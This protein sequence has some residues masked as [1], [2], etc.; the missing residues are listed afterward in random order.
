MLSPSG[1]CETLSQHLRAVGE[2]RF[3]ADVFMDPDRQ[4][5]V[6]FAHREMW[7]RWARISY[8]PLNPDAVSQSLIAGVGTLIRWAGPD[9]TR[10]KI[11]RS[12]WTVRNRRDRVDQDRD[13]A[14]L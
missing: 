10:W 14:T 1:A 5:L 7:Q 6:A 12:P 9:F 3:R 11:T 4:A 2:K 8:M 13:V